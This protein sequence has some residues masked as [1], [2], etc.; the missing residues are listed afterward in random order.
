M[1]AQPAHPRRTLRGPVALVSVAATLALVLAGCGGG[2]KRSEEARHNGAGD[3]DLVDR[4]DR[5]RRE[6]ARQMA[7]AKA[8]P[9][10][11]I[12]VSSARRP[13]TTRCRSSRPPSPTGKYPDVSYAYRELGRP[14]RRV[15]QDAGL[16][17][18][19][20][21]A[22]GG[23]VELPSAARL[24]AA[25]PGGTVIGFPPSSTTWRWSTT[26][27]CSTAGRRLPTDQWTWDDFRNAAK[28]I[29]DPAKKIYGTA[30]SVSGGETPPGTC[31]RCCGRTAG[32]S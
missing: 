30:W 29:N 21:G 28:K 32:R 9:N 24:T 4:S 18:Q 27:S 16:H 25:T 11:T 26:R 17:G 20:Q 6:S 1:R 22:G 31:G 3:A 12:N 5:R 7:L 14:A 2:R 19:G 10:V 8:H 15:G 23:L 13:P